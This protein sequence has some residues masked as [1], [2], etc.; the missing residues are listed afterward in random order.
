MSAEA[1]NELT[2]VPVAEAKRKRSGTAL[3]ERVG[4]LTSF[5]T[6]GLRSRFAVNAFLRLSFGIALLLIGVARRAVMTGYASATDTDE[7]KQNNRSN[8]PQLTLHA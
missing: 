3:P 5:I 1:C 2:A 8:F 4:V 6:V 7:G